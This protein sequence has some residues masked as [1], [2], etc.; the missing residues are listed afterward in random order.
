MVV[1]T[2]LE[3][4]FQS[5]VGE[6]LIIVRLHEFR[7]YDAQ[8]K[9]AFLDVTNM[10]ETIVNQ[11]IP[12]RE[13]NQQELR[14]GPVRA[15]HESMN[16]SSDLRIGVACGDFQWHPWCTRSCVDAYLS[17]LFDELSYLTLEILLGTPGPCSSLKRDGQVCPVRKVCRG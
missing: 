15:V 14:W 1:A 10:F 16:G 4:D 9:Q 8:V 11:C 13:Y 3:V 12:G 17:Q 6:V 2:Q 7:G 5:N